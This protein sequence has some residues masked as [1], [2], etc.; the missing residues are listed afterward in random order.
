MDHWVLA[1]PPPAPFVD[2]AIHVASDCSG[3]GVPEIAFNEYAR[4]HGLSVKSLFASDISKHCRDWLASL[5]FIGALCNDMHSRTFIESADRSHGDTY[6][7]SAQTVHGDLLQIGSSNSHF[8]IYWCGFCCTPF[9]TNGAQQGFADDASSTFFQ[10]IRTVLH[11]KPKVSIFENVTNL[12]SGRHKAVALRLLGFL[13]SSYVVLHLHLKSEWFGLPSSRNRLYIVCL[14]KTSLR[15]S[16]QDRSVEVL[17]EFFLQGLEPMQVA[18]VEKFREFLSSQ[19]Q[20]VRVSLDEGRDESM[21]DDVSSSSVST[22]TTCSS[23]FKGCTCDERTLCK[24]HT[25]KCHTCKSWGPGLK[26]TWRST[27]KLFQ[28]R[29]GTAVKRR[30]YLKKWQQVRSKPKLRRAP[31]YFELARARGLATDVLISPR[32]RCLLKQLSSVENLMDEN[33]ILDTSNSVHRSQ[34]RRDGLVPT[35]TTSSSLY[36]PSAAAFLTSEQALLLTGLQPTDDRL[37][38]ALSGSSEKARL[39]MAGNAMSL[40]V[41]GAVTAVALTMVQL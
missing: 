18:E 32:V 38:C 17:Q 31:H 16:F 20:P 39:A 25:C 10:A 8:D 21:E 3:M 27:H 30:D 2:R 41:V 12:L 4:H 34:L 29:A 5:S 7:M 36:I 23:Y 26:C 9:S 13:G 14:K 19:G 6:I 11:M 37:Q 28:A 1:S 40:P 22:S 15:T 24:V 33:A 35:L